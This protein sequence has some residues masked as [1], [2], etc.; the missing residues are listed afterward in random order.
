MTNHVHEWRILMVTPN[1][2]TVQLSIRCRDLG[3]NEVLLRQNAEA[4]LNEHADLL[5]ALEQMVAIVDFCYK[6]HSIPGPDLPPDVTKGYIDAPRTEA[7]SPS[8]EILSGKWK[9]YTPP[10]MPDN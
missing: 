6:S 9:G 7:K 3:C 4:I 8:K 10:P 5:E 2:A 1:S